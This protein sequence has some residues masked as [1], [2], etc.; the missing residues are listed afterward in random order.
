MVDF[1]T[2]SLLP[3]WVQMAKRKG[4]LTFGKTNKT[5]KHIELMSFQ[6][7]KSVVNFIQDKCK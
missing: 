1:C 5:Y 3:V 4:A 2:Y 7:V 6:Y